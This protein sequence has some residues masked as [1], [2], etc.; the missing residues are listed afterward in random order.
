[1]LTHEQ[2]GPPISLPAAVSYRL[3]SSVANLP[4]STNPGGR[5]E[6]KRGQVAVGEHFGNGT[7]DPGFVDL[8]LYDATLSELNAAAV[9]RGKQAKASVR[10]WERCLIQAYRHAHG[11]RPL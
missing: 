9:S 7:P 6:A 10:E 8:S 3:P 11:V 1:M 4:N 5:H 2:L